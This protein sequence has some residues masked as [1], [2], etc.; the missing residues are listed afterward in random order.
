MHIFKHIKNKENLVST[1]KKLHVKL[2][3]NGSKSSRELC[4]KI[5]T[6]CKLAVQRFVCSV[7]LLKINQHRLML[8]TFSFW[9]II[10][11]TDAYL[12]NEFN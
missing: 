3:Q 1:H 11:N 5:R 6:A 10:L 2:Y 4:R 12:I 9:S 8:R 7:S